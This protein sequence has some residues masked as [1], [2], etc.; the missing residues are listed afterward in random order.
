MQSIDIALPT[1]DLYLLL[2]KHIFSNLPT[3]LNF[4]F[5]VSKRVSSGEETPVA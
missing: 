3:T 4:E 5:G 1:K 2:N